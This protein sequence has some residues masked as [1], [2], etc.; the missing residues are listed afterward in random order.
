MLGGI[1]GDDTETDNESE[2]KEE[3][4]KSPQVVAFSA[5][6]NDKVA[7]CVPILK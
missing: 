4:L 1:L 2:S 6:A 7:Y 5:L 3:A